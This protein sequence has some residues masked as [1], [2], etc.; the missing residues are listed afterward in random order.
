MMK[1]KTL[2]LIIIPFLVNLVNASTD[3]VKT[4]LDSNPKSGFGT[5]NDIERIGEPDIPKG[6]TSQPDFKFA[7]ESPKQETSSHTSGPITIR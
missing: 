4:G 7:T 2:L 1:N 5:Q 6:H 3:P